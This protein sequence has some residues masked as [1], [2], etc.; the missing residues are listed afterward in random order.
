MRSTISLPENLALS[1][2]GRPASLVKSWFQA[3]TARIA[4]W[5]T[6]E[7]ESRELA[8]LSDR[9]LQDIGLTRLD[10]EA[11]VRGHR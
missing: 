10:V 8:Q 4:A 1:R 3:L 6:H 5:R 7:R 9:E 11:F 2:H